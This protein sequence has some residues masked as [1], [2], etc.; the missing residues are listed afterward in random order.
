MSLIPKSFSRITQGIPEDS[1]NSGKDN[2]FGSAFLLF[3]APLSTKLL[4]K[5]MIIEHEEIKQVKKI[6]DP[7]NK[8][9]GSSI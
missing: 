5:G 8:S 9:A 4:E 2:C 1:G 6:A 3:Y 7:S